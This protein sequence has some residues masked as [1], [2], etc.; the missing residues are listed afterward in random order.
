MQSGYALAANGL[1]A[2]ADGLIPK[3]AGMLTGRD[4]KRASMQALISGGNLQDAVDPVAR[5]DGDMIAIITQF[6]FKAGNTRA[7]DGSVLD[8]MPDVSNWYTNEFLL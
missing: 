1:D 4:L 5:I 6:Q 3:T 2:A 7:V 8:A